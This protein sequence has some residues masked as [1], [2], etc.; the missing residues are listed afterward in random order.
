MARRRHVLLVDLSLVRGLRCVMACCLVTLAVNPAAAQRIANQFDQQAADAT[1]SP[2]P[3]LEQQRSV[4]TSIARPYIPKETT[5]PAAWPSSMQSHGSVV[6]SI[7]TN[8]NSPLV[9][10]DGPSPVGSETIQA[11]AAVPLGSPSGDATVQSGFS[12]QDGSSE[13]SG[14]VQTQYVEP[15]TA[16]SPT[17]S[18]F[19]AAS[20]QPEVL[21]ADARLEQPRMADGFSQA[22]ATPA[23]EPPAELPVDPLLS[24][25][26]SLQTAMVV[27]RVGPE[28]VLESD[29]ITPAVAAWLEKVT[30]GLPPEQVRELKMQVY[31]HLL[32][33]Y[34]E[35]MIVYVDA[36][37][38]IPAEALP[39]IE[40]KVNQAFDAEQLP[41]LM[42][43]AG[44][45]NSLEYEQLLRSRG[46]SLDRLKKAF[47]ERAIAQQWLAQALEAGAGGE[48][49]HAEL[50][51]YYQEHLSDYEY[52]AKAK[53]EELCVRFGSNRTRE[54]A[55]GVLAGL[56]NRVL[57]GETF[58]EVA[59]QGSEGPTASQ[60]GAY[61]WTSEGSLRSQVINEAIFS[62]PI[63]KL[64]TILED[65]SGL[66]IVRVVERT[67]AGRTSF[68]EAQVGIRDALRAERHEKAVDEYLSKVRERTPVWT[69]FDDEEDRQQ[70]VRMV[71]GT[72][73]GR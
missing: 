14:V 66:H 15:A 44:V 38:T 46:Q 55:W 24:Q 47:F 25:A 50:I 54:E 59:K 23:G 22:G 29:L 6:S 30:P 53:F 42:Q 68:L 4:D 72:A 20:G 35:S 17:V 9:P 73:A 48:I 70:D 26:Q 51:A 1:R 65:E 41:R 34:V 69:I 57:T 19:G 62:L 49:P 40:A 32:T 39:E 71:R 13:R 18:Q 11:L 21:G 36:C 45:A 7:R 43:E 27:A 63:G 52:S 2:T 37:R 28:V 67:D 56:G 3:G 8:P 31:E 60:G 33:Q 10:I 61:D 64:S 16:F 58:A 12:E 5:R